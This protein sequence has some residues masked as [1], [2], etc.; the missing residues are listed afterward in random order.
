MKKL[1]LAGG[2]LLLATLVAVLYT[3]LETRETPADRTSDA[4]RSASG[5]ETLVAAPAEPISAPSS[6]AQAETSTESATPPNA[7]RSE[8]V[9]ARLDPATAHRVTGRVVAAA[10]TPADE[11]FEILAFRGLAEPSQRV[12]ELPSAALDA[13]STL[14]S[15]VDARPD[16]SFELDVPGDDEGAWVALRARYSYG[17]EAVRVDAERG[18]APIVLEPKL[19]GWVT[20][21]LR[22]PS[23][24]T[25]EAFGSDDTELE[26]RFDVMRFVGAMGAADTGDLRMHSTRATEALEFE[27]RGVAASTNY[28]VR[29]APDALAA[30]KSDKF[31]VAAGERVPLTLQLARGGTLV[32]RVVDP[33]GTPVAGAKLEATID[34]LVFGQGGF[35]VRDGSTDD[36]GQFSL[37]AVYAGEVELA[38]ARDGFLE[39]RLDAQSIDGQTTE[40]GDI[41]LGRGES[42]AGVVLWPDGAPVEN[43]EVEASFDPAAL[44]GMSAFNAMQGASGEDETDASG[45]FEIRGLGKGPFALSAKAKPANG[46]G[47]ELRARMSG[48]KPGTL[49]VVLRLQAPL[50]VAGRVVDTAGAPIANCAVVAHEDVGGIIPGLGGRDEGTRSNADGTFE[51]VGLAPGKWSLDADAEGYTRCEPVDVELPRSA[52]APVLEL[53]LVRGGSVSGIVLDAAGQPQSGARVREKRAIG[54]MMTLAR[55]VA[56]GIEDVKSDA[57]GAFRLAGVAAGTRSFTAAADGFAESEAVTV[58][59]RPSEETPD[60]VLRLRVGGRITG[61]LFGD[62]GKPIAGGQILVQGAADA[63]NQRFATTDPLGH[64]EFQHVTPGTWNVMYFP[65]FGTSPSGEDGETPDFSQMFANM[66]MTTATVKDGEETHVV[67]GAP[68]ADPVQLEGRVLASGD[69]V[70]G[71]VL[72]LI[73]DGNTSMSG[74]KFTTTDK[75]GRYSMRLDAPG[76]Y[77][78]SVQRPGVAGQQQT[79]SHFI[80]V[81][82]EPRHEHDVHLPL[83]SIRGRVLDPDGQPAKGARVGLLVDGPVPN[84]TLVGEHFAEI[85]TGDDGRYE[86]VWLKPGEYTVSVGGAAFG[87]L[88]GGGASFGRQVRPGVKVREGEATDGVDFKL[89]RSGKIEGL[90]RDSGG[91]PVAE[92][93]IFLRD[94]AGR[95]LERFSMVATDATGKFAYDGLEPGEYTVLARTSAETSAPSA[96]ARVNEGQSTQVELALGAGTML[97]VSLSGDDGQP[98]ECSVAVY[99]EHGQ[100]VNGVMSLAEI[101]QAFTNG[102]FS[103]KEQK[104]GPLPPG[105]YKVTVTTSDGRKTTKPVTLTGQAERKLNVRM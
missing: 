89:R 6:A 44:G 99:D 59:V 61:E 95:V 37:A 22:L 29:G 23:G 78:L 24:A 70:P 92:A 73:A 16:G 100:Q 3:W 94:G 105:K 93:A 74:L 47:P 11:R 72:T 53:V 7:E 34:A 49:D 52:D 39:K 46:E 87:G 48:I 64:F 102:E 84:G 54:D 32:G 19:G 17:A 97:I 9:A 101:M 20:G 8:H 30:F 15:R 27:F 77:A 36:R 60:L 104:V 41:V 10:N 81:P 62:D 67:L 5:A 33:D 88:F 65:S 91:Q 82:K 26:L 98:I 85:S 80:E 69:G 40:L 4:T 1:I 43:V 76:R 71:L 12:M 96:P 28:S 56:A 68:P 86:L 57:Q 51:V 55:N 2:L 31:A 90:V 79:I 63:L 45:R 66:K 75:D 13:E 103:S 14:V 18:D 83:G 38:V 25:A 35:E 21:S 42:V 58:E 50:S